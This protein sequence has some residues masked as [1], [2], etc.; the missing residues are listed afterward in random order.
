MDIQQ[1]EQKMIDEFFERLQRQAEQSTHPDSVPSLA[2]ERPHYMTPQHIIERQQIEDQL[3]MLVNISVARVYEMLQQRFIAEM[4]IRDE[5]LEAA[6]RS[7]EQDR[8]RA[9]CS[10]RKLEIFIRY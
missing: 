10:E 3:R 8:E 6:L 7:A 5:K 1:L 4:K 2:P 9:E